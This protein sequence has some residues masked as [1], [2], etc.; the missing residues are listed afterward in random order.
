[1]SVMTMPFRAASRTAMLPVMVRPA[2]I[3][4]ITITVRTSTKV[5]PRGGLGFAFE[6]LTVILDSSRDLSGEL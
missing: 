6:F 3:P 4:M 5:K 1:M 2:R